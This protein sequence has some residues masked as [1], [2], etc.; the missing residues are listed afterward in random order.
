MQNARAGANDLATT[1]VG[2]VDAH[3]FEGIMRQHRR[4][5]LV[6]LLS[7]LACRF[8]PGSFLC[9]LAACLQPGGLLRLLASCEL[10]RA[11]KKRHAHSEVIVLAEGEN[12]LEQS[13]KLR[14][15]L[16]EARYLKTFCL[17]QLRYLHDDLLE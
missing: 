1:L 8:K 9:N 16:A 13:G 7:F 14:E 17:N 11:L 4:L 3:D 15:D 5:H 12:L 2:E 6:S 10:D